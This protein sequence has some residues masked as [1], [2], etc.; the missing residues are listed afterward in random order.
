MKSN[1]DA[2]KDLREAEVAAVDTAVRWAV[3]EAMYLAAE[4]AIDEVVYRAV[5]A[6]VY[7]TVYLAAQHD[8]LHPA[9]GDFLAA[10][11]AEAP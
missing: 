11:G 10:A 2:N 1:G 3:G 5:C 4:D 7:W 6:N 9:L 8:Q